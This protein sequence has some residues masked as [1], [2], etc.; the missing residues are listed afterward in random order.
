M[1]RALP[2]AG[3]AGARPRRSRSRVVPA[4]VGGGSGG[5][6][7]G[8][9]LVGKGAGPGPGGAAPALG[10]G[11]SRDRPVRRAVL[12]GRLLPLPL[13]RLPLRAG[14]DAVRAGARGL[15]RRPRGPGALSG[16]PRPNQLPG[17][18]DHLR[19]RDATRL[20][21][22]LRRC[23]RQRGGAAG[24]LHPLRP[25]HD[26]RS[27]AAG[28][29][30]R[31]PALRVVSA[32]GEGGR[33]HGPPRRLRG[34]L[35]ARRGAAGEAGAAP[36]G[37]GAPRFRRGGESPGAGAGAVRPASDP[38]DPRGGLR[39][40]A[41]DPLPA[42]RLAGGQRPPDALG[43]RARLGVQRLGLRAADPAAAERG[44]PGGLRRAVPCGSGVA[45]LPRPGSRR[46]R[47]AGRPPLRPAPRPGPGGESLVPAL[48]VALCGD[49][50]EP[51]GVDGFGGGAALLCHR[52][53]PPGH[54]P[55]S[56][57]APAVGAGSGI[58]DGRARAGGRRRVAPEGGPAG[59]TA[60]TAG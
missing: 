43:V 51:L 36:R 46:A 5:D 38:L 25:A 45:L 28:A 58:R 34:L 22:R 33:L 35:R 19:P 7:R 12:R 3:V 11:V 30:P 60:C 26:R 2:R 44:R 54:E 50:S 31:R 13:G 9:R 41:R 57:R 8:L 56:L 47:P 55:P 49:P 59:G 42:V 29:A 4:G 17:A 27:A 24:H 16:N 14:R 6:V 15:L 40:S 37:S 23:A 20:P 53:E 48:G 18:A 21:A 52:T 39:R 1:R 10:G 32:G